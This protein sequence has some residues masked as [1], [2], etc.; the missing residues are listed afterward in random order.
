MTPQTNLEIQ[1]YFSNHPAA[2]LLAEIAQFKLNGSLRF[3]F[4]EQKIIVYFDGGEIVFAVSN[5]R[6]HRLYHILLREE[7]ISSAR[8]KEI[9]NFANDLELKTNLIKQDLFSEKEINGIF[10][11]QL[12]QILQTSLDWTDGSWVFSS[13]VRVKNDLRFPVDAA[14]LL[15]AFGRAM[16]K[17]KIIRRFKSLQEGFSVKTVFPTHINLLP[18]EA[19]VLSRFNGETL[20]VEEMKNISG[21]SEIET[22]KNLYVLWLGGFLTRQKWN[23]AFSNEN[24]SAISSAKIELKKQAA[25]PQIL[26]KKVFETQTDVVEQ[27]IEIAPPEPP[28]EELSLEKYLERVENAANHYEIF[29]VSHEEE[30]SKIKSAYFNLA[31]HF[32]PDLFHRRIEEE[33]HRRIQN[34]FTKLAQAYETLKS[35]ESR[36]V[37]DFKLRKE[38]G[39]LA[40]TSNANTDGTQNNRQMMEHQAAENFEQGF[41]LIMRDA[42]AEAIPYLARAVHLEGGNAR[43][44]A[45]FGKA[46][47][48]DKTTYRQA[49]SELQAAIRIETDNLDYRLMLAKLFIKIGFIKRAEGE[50]G[51]IL[52]RSPNYQ[53]ALSILDSLHDK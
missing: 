7:K 53:E 26:N 24:L 33:Q 10:S 32:H 5:S 35:K 34:A 3:S 52:E 1:G 42:Y 4:S 21:L 39:N 50:L 40:K 23:S 22:L 48:A 15:F 18:Q 46:L 38:I 49:E 36:E 14:Q 51:R 9:P 44:R 41:D 20:S 8:L 28:K 12:G 31:K 47:S 19:F 30:T 6:E 43:Y 11:S 16:T 25:A 17:E 45:Y 2:E 37:Y 13:L 29:D 27:V